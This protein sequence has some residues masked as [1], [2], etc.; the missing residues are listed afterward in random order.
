MIKYEVEFY[1]KDNGEIPAEKFLCS[2]DKKLRAKFAGLIL[3]LKDKGNLL[4]LYR[5]EH[6]EWENLRTF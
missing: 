4:R 2:L 6:K 1:Q 3:I 5:E